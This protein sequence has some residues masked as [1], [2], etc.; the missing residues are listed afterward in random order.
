[1]INEINDQSVDQLISMLYDAPLIDGG[2]NRAFADIS[3]AL[4]HSSILFG[5]Q[6]T[7][8]VDPD[9]IEVSI[10]VDP[11]DLQ[12]FIELIMDDVAN[13]LFPCF[14]HS[15][16]G[17]CFR[18][19]DFLD[20]RAIESAAFFET[21]AKPSGQT[22]YLGLTVDRCDDYI[23]PLS[24]HRNARQPDYQDDEVRLLQFLTPHMRR[25]FK[26]D[27]ELRTSRTHSKAMD[28]VLA[29]L[30]CGVIL[31][32]AQ[33]EVIFMNGIAQTFVDQRDGLCSEAGVLRSSKREE[34]T[35]LAEAV[36]N[37]AV[38]RSTNGDGVS[39]SRACGRKLPC[40]IYP[41]RGRRRE[42]FDQRASVMLL[43][44][45][46]DRSI[47]GMAGL[48]AR[49]YQLSPRQAQLVE[50]I[51][52][53]D[54]L[55]DAADAMGVSYETVKTQLRRVFE[56]T[57]TKSQNELVRLIASGPLPIFSMSNSN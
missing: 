16:V 56:K 33:A 10:L 40:L 25:A 45:T 54:V 57:E 7:R 3:S 39:L 8:F 42:G 43:F 31:L 37:S 17:K 50:H 38:Q 46:Q 11:C 19:E 28:A 9:P 55:Q 34:R 15:K 22:N 5:S 12:K 20:R 4:N 53:G 51:L 26:L 2:W 27:R 35:L 13:P 44:R 47:P 18:F 52:S 23:L 29:S 24:V 6:S 36:A 30:D 14:F 48:I 49:I 21:I 41:V 32:S 1:M